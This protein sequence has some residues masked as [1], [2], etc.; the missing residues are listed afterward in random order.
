[1]EALIAR[2]LQIRGRVQGVGYRDSMRRE[3][4]HLGLAGWVRNCA[5]GTVEAFVQGTPVD[6][7]RLT[8]WARQGP[9]FAKVEGVEITPSP[10][11]ATALA[12]FV[13]KF[14]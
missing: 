2:R 13:I 10:A 4:Q 8:D 5:D 3:A 6:V 12:D 1:M 7:D 14:D 9:R 11:D